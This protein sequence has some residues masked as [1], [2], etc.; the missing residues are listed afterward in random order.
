MVT[1]VQRWVTSDLKEFHSEQDADAHESAVLALQNVKDNLGA[2]GGVGGPNGTYH[3]LVYLF[4][5][6]VITWKRPT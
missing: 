6:G 4:K 3:A 1:Q 5:H 2:V